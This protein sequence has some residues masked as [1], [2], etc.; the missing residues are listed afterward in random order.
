MAF[1][2]SEA[3][4]GLESRLRGLLDASS[5]WYECNWRETKAKHREELGR[6]GEEKR[7]VAGGLVKLALLS[8]IEGVF[9]TQFAPTPFGCC[10]KLERW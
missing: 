10:G 4:C 6:K 9:I 2:S 8:L 3:L 5:V 1:D 7:E